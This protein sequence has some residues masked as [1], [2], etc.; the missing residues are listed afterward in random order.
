MARDVGA[1]DLVFLPLLRRE[2][3]GSFSGGT[4]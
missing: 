1:T 2:A 4:T 3:A